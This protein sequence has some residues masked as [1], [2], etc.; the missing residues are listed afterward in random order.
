MPAHVVRIAGCLGCLAV[1][2]AGC[3]APVPPVLAFDR[4]DYERVFEAAIESAREDGL[5]P[6]VADRDLGV[7]ETT[8]RTAGSV[9][10]PWRTDNAGVE[11]MLAHTVNFERRRARFEFVPEG[12]AAPVP[13]PQAPSVG[14]AIP[15]SDRAEQRFD[16]MKAGGRIELRAWVY[17]D[18]AFLPNQSFGRWTLGETRYSID[19][20]QARRPDDPGTAIDTQWTPI[21]RDEPYEQRL[22]QRI[23][24]LLAEWQ[25]HDAGEA[26]AEAVP[27]H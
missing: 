15:G 10:E 11:E 18:R 19:P 24:A 12:F 8:P 16:L 1:G 23:H 6:V 2:L 5:D 13:D 9:V 27:G 25:A 26:R 7:I 22:M 20:T 3:A 21:G 4:A 14:P 17:V